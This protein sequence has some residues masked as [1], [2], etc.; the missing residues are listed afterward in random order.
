MPA[1]YI[2]LLKVQNGGMISDEFD[3]SGLTT[4]YGIGPTA[5][6]YNSLE[7]RFE[8]WNVEWEYPDIGFPFGETQSADHDMYYMGFRFAD[9]NGE[10]RI[11]RID[12]EMDNEVYFV[13]DNLV[14]FIK[15]IIANQEIEE[16]RLD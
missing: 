15:L 6:T 16:K 3:E 10:P 9:E 7:E 14:E 12:N 4:I 5:D 1:S 11:V 8:N 2:E 13:A